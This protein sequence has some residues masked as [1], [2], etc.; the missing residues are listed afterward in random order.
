MSRADER[1]PT[2]V[3]FAAIDFSETSA[4]ALR[5]AGAIAKR[6]GARLVLG[7]V[8]EVPI[9]AEYPISMSSPLDDAAV[10]EMARERLEALANEVAA[11]GLTTDT[12]I[13]RGTPGPYL[14]EMAEKSSAD[15]LVIGTRGLSGLSHLVFGSTAETVV[16]KATCAVLTVH[17]ENAE[18]DAP[19]ETVV[20]PT[21]LSG[22]APVAVDAFRSHFGEDVKPTLR[23]VYADPT[24]PYLDGFEHASLERWQMPDARREDLEARM[25]KTVETLEADGFVV[26][27][28]V[29]DGA[30]VR[31]VT[32]L[33]EESGADLIVMTTHGRSA[34]LNALIGRTA[35]RIVQLAPCP[36]LTV[37]KPGSD[38]S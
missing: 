30:P 17:P 9:L 26:E 20:V 28:S 2:R 27:R 21:D 32:D 38:A 7:H 14:L 10:H 4:L 8:V 19:I 33:A 5:H 18:P 15:L 34:L 29:V 24:P 23:L 1:M 35:Q 25:Q 16:R 6:C 31:A 3:V 12:F 11:D 13:E 37:R 22:D 36:V